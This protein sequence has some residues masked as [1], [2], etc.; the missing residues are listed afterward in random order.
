MTPVSCE[1]AGA[2]STLVIEDGGGHRR[3]FRVATWIDATGTRHHVQGAAGAFS[4]LEVPRFSEPGH[5]AVAGALIAPMPGKV[6]KIRV[7][8]GDTV[9]AG[10]TLLVLEAMKMEHSVHAPAA[11]VVA[12]LRV[13]LGEQV[14]SDQVLAV[15]AAAAV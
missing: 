5:A 7:A 4:L 1:R 11:G 10:A 3:R 14:A 15:V 6:V 2:V 13:A 12:E 8:V 9:A